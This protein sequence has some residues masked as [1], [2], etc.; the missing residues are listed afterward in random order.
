[1][2][3]QAIRQIHSSGHQ[4]V[5]EFTGAGSAALAA[6][7]A[8]PGSSRTILEATD[9]YSA[10]SVEELLGATPEKAVD[11]QTAAAMADRA[12]PRACRLGD[13]SKPKLGAGCTATIATDRAKRGEHR[14]CL[15]VRSSQSITTVD[16]V[17]TKGARD[18][19]GEEAL[20]TALIVDALSRAT[21][22]GPVSLDLLS[23]EQVKHESI[24]QADP[25][26]RLL[27]GAASW[28]VIESDGRRVADQK[29]DGAIYSGSFNPLHFGHE[30]LAAAAARASGAEVTFELAAANAEKSTLG[31]SELERRLAPFWRRHRVVVTRV[32]LFA[33]K[34]QLF[35][36]C[37]F[38]LGYD[39]A[40]R[41]ID[42]RFY[43]DSEA[44]RDQA[45]AALLAA[46]CR[47]LVAG[48]LEDGKFKTLADLP[49]SQEARKLF[50]DLPEFRADVSATNLRALRAR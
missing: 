44:D 39:T 41:L 16:L 48:R 6:L 42:P 32:P 33:D 13:D 49:I 3:P 26:D 7:H 8:E 30:A 4:L 45:L 27:A 18:R 35:P 28:V 34:A 36:G 23:G 22:G 37:T 47:V 21:G 29:V 20:I 43:G 5:L 17:F 19:H 14:C 46:G 24:A 15:A 2:I 31:R 12:Y 9:R 1:V 10:A 38:V 40:A 11:P 25:L 50:V